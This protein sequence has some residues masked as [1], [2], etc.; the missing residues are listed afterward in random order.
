MWN[1]STASVIEDTTD[2]SL[3]SF[4]WTT[5]WTEVAL[6]LLLNTLVL[7]GFFYFLQSV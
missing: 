1:I 5:Q 2:S 4:E 3:M 7:L 6:E